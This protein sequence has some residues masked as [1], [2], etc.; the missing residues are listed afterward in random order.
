MLQTNILLLILIL[1]EVLRFY[2]SWQYGKGEQER[3]QRE[4]KE[5]EDM[6]F[7]V[8]KR[9]MFEAKQLMDDQM[10]K[11]RQQNLEDEKRKE[12]FP[13]AGYKW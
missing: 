9:Q 5:Q 6:M 8:Q 10:E 4:L 11:A 7:R 1:L 3:R 13:R 2:I 12:V